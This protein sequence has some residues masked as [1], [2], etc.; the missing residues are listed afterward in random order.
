LLSVEKKKSEREVLEFI[1]LSF[2]IHLIKIDCL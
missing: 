1:F 2:I